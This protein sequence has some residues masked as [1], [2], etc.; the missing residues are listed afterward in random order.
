GFSS[1]YLTGV[2]GEIKL[3]KVYVHPARQRSGVGGALI[4]R[5]AAHGR[6]AGCDTLI[7]AVNKQNAKAIA[8]YEKRGFSVREAVRVDI[9]G[10]FVMDD[11]IMARS[12][13]Q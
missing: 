6:A 4:E 2:A 11:F 13:A 8:A 1:G 3:D 7:L 9:G 12:I 5:V 10:G